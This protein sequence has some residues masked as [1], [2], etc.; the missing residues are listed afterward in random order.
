MILTF[1]K[2]F[3]LGVHVAMYAYVWYAIYSNEM[4]V[5]Y[6]LRGNWTLIALYT[7]FL[8]IF[9]KGFGALKVGYRK[10]WDLL[11]SQI[12]SLFFVNAIT[13]LQLALINGHWK[14]LERSGP[15]FAL[16]AIEIISLFIWDLIFRRV[17]YRI[18]PPHK[19]LLVYGCSED[20]DR[21]VSRLS[22]RPDK[23]LI[24]DRI[25]ISEGLDEVFD[26][27]THNQA[28]LISDIPASDRNQISKFCFRADKRCY[29]IPKISD[30]LLRY[31]NDIDLFDAPVLLIHGTNMSTLQTIGKRAMD[32]VGSLIGLIVLSPLFLVVAILIRSYDGGPVF[33]TQDRLTLNGKV[34]RIFKFRSMIVESERTGARLAMTDDDRI[35]PIGRFLRASHIDE[36][37]QL[38][39]ILKGEMS[40]VGPRPERPEIAADYCRE[41]PEFDFRLKAKA[42]LTGYAQVYGQYNTPPHDKIKLD[43]MYIEN[44]SLWLDVKLIVL[45]IKILFIKEKTAGVSNDQTTAL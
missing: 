34:F 15:M 17:Y 30:I 7:V 25:N 45:T 44:Y 9:Y 28:V 8:L 4:P 2:L 3:I 23:Y 22:K 26:R 24:S 36:L 19:V 41:I 43:L 16:L 42:G 10:T 38:I 27:I 29:I 14:F 37:P 21:T 1:S 12:L 33:Y 39:N 5:K 6:Y 40:I 11:Y 31:A 18:Y 35:T 13:Y 20:S 32:I